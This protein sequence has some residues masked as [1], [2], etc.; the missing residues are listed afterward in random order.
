MGT[1]VDELSLNSK[2]KFHQRF[3]HI[4]HHEED[5]SAETSQ[6]SLKSTT[7]STKSKST[8][9]LLAPLVDF[10]STPK[11]KR[12]KSQSSLK[13]TTSSTSDL[14]SKSESFIEKYHFCSN[15]IIGRG[16]SGVVKLAKSASSDKIYAVK[17][18]RKKRRD[19]SYREYVKK[20][21][22]EF[23][24]GSTLHHLNI[25]ETVDIVHDGEH[26][27][28][29]MEY[30]PGGDLFRVISQAHLSNDE[31][32][33]CFKQLIEGVSYLHSLGVAHRDLKPENLLMDL[34]GHLKI[35]DFGV[36]DVFKTCWE[37][38]A[39]LSKGICGSA[40]YIAPEEFKNKE[41]DAT[42]VDVWAC[43]IIYYALVFHGIPWEVATEKD[44]HYRHY[45][46]HRGVKFEPLVRLLHG[47]QS[48]LE[49]MLEP[50]PQKR[51]S[52][53]EIKK[54]EW[55]SKISTC[56]DGKIKH[57]HTIQSNK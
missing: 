22:S 24:I 2:K 34:E 54:D 53:E 29:V 41:Y 15:K 10:L 35:T 6:T 19:E 8:K 7:K 45:L 37:S 50:D 9:G 36:S 5:G 18:F 52:I 32:D 42:K 49:R 4:L 57:S 56:C 48:L 39:H 51:I 16:S 12:K 47:P 55:F 25:V 3:L 23:C 40:P 31:I 17:E 14:P 46:E 26:W 38:K 28:E 33:C 20:M 21:S 43:G 13:S 30:C 11:E 1:E 44:P 27:Y